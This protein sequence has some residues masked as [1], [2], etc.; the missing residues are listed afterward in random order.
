MSEE[1]TIEQ[2]EGIAWITLDRPAKANAMTVDMSRC[3]T[4]AIVRANDDERVKAIVLTAAGEKIFS[5]G[6]DVRETAPDGDE[7]AQRARRSA[8]T[9]A[10]Q[11]AV[12]DSGKPVVVA[13]NGAAIGGGAML[14]MLADSCVAVQEATLSLPE[15]DIGIASFSGANIVQTLGG[16]A[17]TADLIL[18]G[19]R[20]PAA[21]A[22]ARGLIQG[23]V[24]RAE[25]RQAAASAAARL[26]DKPAD[27][28][29]DIKR[30]ING[31]LK[32]A[33]AEAREEHARHR[34][35]KKH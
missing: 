21:E 19:R 27:A 14:A 10:L 12:M 8:S 9:A 24:P 5:A 34:S 4:E 6:V 33:M 23:V 16:R 2:S 26:G 1:V 31:P 7:A 30:W 29:K 35:P 17:V 18:T 25:L 28:F 32:A 22:A 13:L 3:V 15:I 11:D 20:M